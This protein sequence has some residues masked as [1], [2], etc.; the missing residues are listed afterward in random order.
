MFPGCRMIGEDQ[1]ATEGEAYE[2]SGERFLAYIIPDNRQR[3][4]RSK[5]GRP[6]ARLPDPT[7]RATAGTREV[8]PILEDLGLELAD[9]ADGVEHVGGVAL[10]DH[11][12]RSRRWRNAF[13]ANEIFDVSGTFALEWRYENGHVTTRREA[14]QPQSPS[15]SPRPPEDP[16]GTGGDIATGADHQLVAGEAGGG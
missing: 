11:Y 2:S 7:C 12:A 6:Q 15:G 8:S 10:G 13:D 14:D 1:P 4:R 3:D 5:R 9:D 16:G